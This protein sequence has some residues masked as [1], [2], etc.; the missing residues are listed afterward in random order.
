MIESYMFVMNIDHSGGI[1]MKKAIYIILSTILVCSLLVGCG[2]KEP[3]ALSVID[4]T[5]IEEE[6]VTPSETNDDA[7]TAP[8]GDGVS[9]QQLRDGIY[10]KGDDGNAFAQFIFSSQ[11]TFIYSSGAH[12]GG[13][14]TVMGTYELKDNNI[15]M[16][17]TSAFAEN[18]G[19]E[20]TLECE[21]TAQ[22]DQFLFKYLSGEGMDDYLSK[23]GD[24]LTFKT[25]T[26]LD[27]LTN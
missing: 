21:I 16:K 3:E 27:E 13:A 24:E 14:D 25:G 1:H 2:S 6:I 5:V 22:G 10:Y 20:K 7:E 12:A 17:Y 23:S 8:S 26:V 4:S 9:F 11:T 15:T 19:E 18:A